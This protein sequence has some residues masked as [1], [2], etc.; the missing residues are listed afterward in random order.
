IPLSPGRNPYPITKADGTTEDANATNGGSGQLPAAMTQFRGPNGEWTGNLGFKCHACHS[1]GVGRPGEGDGGPGYLSRSGAGLAAIGLLS[2]DLGISGVPS[3][4]VGLAFSL[5]GQS[6]GTNNA[7]FG[8]IVGITYPQ[9]E[10]ARPTQAAG[11]LTSGSTA[12]M[13]TPAWWNVG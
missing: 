11:W 5:F 13:D 12:S 9:D 6:R 8:N 10:F 1:S 7:Q 2:R 3:G 4:A